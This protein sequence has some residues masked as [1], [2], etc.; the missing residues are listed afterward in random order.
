MH[1]D[2]HATH[3]DTEHAVIAI[4]LGGTKL[5]SALVTER[6]K[7][8]LRGACMIRGLPGPA[9]A[10]RIAGEITRIERDAGASFPAGIAVPGIADPADG[11]VWAPNI[12]GW[13]W[14]GLRE[15]LAESLDRPESSFVI[16]NDRVC[17]IAGE[18]WAGAAKGCESAVFIAVGTGIGAG[19]MIDGRIV[20]G[21]SGAAGSIGWFAFSGEQD[22]TVAPCACLESRAS[23]E[24]I[25]ASARKLA[26]ASA[27]GAS[28]RTGKSNAD[29]TAGDVFAAFDEGDGIAER[30]IADCIAC[31]G[32]AAANIVSMIDPEMIVFGGG[33]FGP[34]A[35]FIDAIRREASRR[36][37]PVSM[38]RVR[39][40]VSALGGDAPLLGA[41]R[42]AM[43]ALHVKS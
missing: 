12:P 20:R 33:V 37:Q 36:A 25:A 16:E 1:E 39:I 26:D 19:I 27:A 29:I 38:D 42:C 31:W 15:K 17:S 32:M 10:E 14:I 2:M 5:R 35:R 3:P 28:L 30:V 22:D 41:A 11:R 23:G 24:G 40:T 8:N 18:V 6:G 7:M 34:G 4:D 21:S 9:V 43:D 13:E